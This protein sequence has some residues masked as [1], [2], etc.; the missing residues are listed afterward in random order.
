MTPF[1]MPWSNFEIIQLDN[2]EVEERFLMDK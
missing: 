1:S 2:G